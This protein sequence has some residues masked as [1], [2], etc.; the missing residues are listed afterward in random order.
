MS[1]DAS[2][3]HLDI[4]SIGLIGLGIIR[5]LPRALS[6]TSQRG[7]RARKES[8]AACRLLFTSYLNFAQHCC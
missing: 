2:M 3:Q 1:L 4:Q 8:T 7:V 5:A 6:W